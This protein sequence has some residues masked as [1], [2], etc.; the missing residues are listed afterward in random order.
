MK[1]V[2]IIGAGD[3]GYPLAHCITKLGLVNVLA[4]RG[5]K[6]KGFGEL[7][8]IAT[9][10]YD[11]IAF[12]KKADVI[13][14]AV[15]PAQ[16]G[17]V[18][19]EIK[20]YLHEEKLFISTAACKKLTFIRSILGENGNIVRVMPNIAITCMESMT[21]ISHE[22]NLP[23][24]YSLY[25]EDLFSKMGK[26]NVVPDERMNQA[27]IFGAT[28]LAVAAYV[29]KSFDPTAACFN[30]RDVYNHDHCDFFKAI[31]LEITEEYS[32]PDSE[33]VVEQVL[34]GLYFLVVFQGKTLDEIIHLVATPGGCTEAV[35][36]VLMG[37]QSIKTMLNSNAP[38][39]SYKN[40]CVDILSYAIR[41]GV[42]R[43]ESM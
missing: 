17:G 20:P 12:V 26:V 11:N 23:R 16:L 18:L 24:N 33:K 7:E 38:R 36:K 1:N 34:Q 31:F 40:L 6:A 14:S 15:R 32:F 2:L 39:K 43:L 27:T 8:S 41:M 9:C 5:D 22:K 37:N 28:L 4:T 42:D 19:A 30:I 3:L 13:I 25:V 29:F 10:G 21:F 35:L